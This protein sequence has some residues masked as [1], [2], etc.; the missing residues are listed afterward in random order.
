MKKVRAI[1]SAVMVIIIIV[2]ALMLAEK[3]NL[4]KDDSPVTVTISEG[5]STNDIYKILK[6]EKLVKTKIGFFACLK[7]SKYNGKLR[8]GTFN[9]KRNMSINDIFKTLTTGGASVETFTLTVP[10]GFSA[11][12]IAQRLSE[13]NICTS[14]EFL[15]ALND[16]YDY[17]FIKDIPKKN[18]KYKLQGF[19]YP[20]TYEFY[21]TATAHEIIDTL[22][23]EFEKNYS[24]I[25]NNSGMSMFDTITLASL[26]EREAKLAEERPKIAGVIKNRLKINML[27]QIDA[28]VVY[29]VSDGLY[30]TDR[31][32][33]KDLETDSPYNTYKYTG[34]PA[35]PICS[36][37]I[38]SIEAA[39][40]SENHN[41]LYYHTDETK[42]DGSHIFTE[43]YSDHTNTQ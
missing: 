2:C 39:I 3:I 21:T 34:L 13:M 36:P 28:T 27:L 26:V 22:L 29:A 16:D 42:K 20:S 9:L 23:A 11:E 31:V 30:D 40:N 4:S 15:D 37:G 8:Y 32:L 10:E 18:Y 5:A 17:S 12:K 38:K 6:D 1:M 7:T 19:L 41:Y 43:N 33:Y 24:S 25:K 35:G 14:K